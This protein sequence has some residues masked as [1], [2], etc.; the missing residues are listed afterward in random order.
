MEFMELKE[1]RGKTAVQAMRNL[2][3]FMKGKGV[4]TIVAVGPSARE[5]A[6]F[7]KKAFAKRY[8]QEPRLYSLG[9]ID[10]FFQKSES[11][12]R[13]GIPL[14]DRLSSRLYSGR[15][16]ALIRKTRP[17]LLRE[18]DE[19]VLLFDETVMTGRSLAGAKRVFEEH[20]GAKRVYTGALYRFQ[21]KPPAEAPSVSGAEISL[22][23]FL[24]QVYPRR[25]EK[26]TKIR[27]LKTMLSA[28]PQESGRLAQDLADYR[29]ITKASR[30][31]YNGILE[32]I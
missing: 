16:A 25:T 32:K 19:P 29:F 26:I 18:L 14:L 2:L 22:F 10:E 15:A 20:L 31:F 7:L 1:N 4:K 13:R 28:K 23:S 3:D 21:E 6:L 12:R 17:R 11:I 30:R 8:A 27:E 5:P 24:P 9:R